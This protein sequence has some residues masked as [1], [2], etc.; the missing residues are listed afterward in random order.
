M[1]S[2]GNVISGVIFLL[3]VSVFS[4]SASENRLHDRIVFSSN[5]SG[6]WDIWAVDPDG[7]N[8]TPVLETT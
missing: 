4:A 1:R 3:M 6:S 8:L 2:A 7:K 5:Y